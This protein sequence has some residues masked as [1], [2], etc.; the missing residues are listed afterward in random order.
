M[1]RARRFGGLAVFLAAGAAVV[2]W[3]RRPPAR[4]R[5]WTVSRCEL[6]SAGR[7]GGAPAVFFVTRQG[8]NYRACQR[9]SDQPGVTVGERIL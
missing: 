2:N 1:N 3:A 9:C 5:G 8:V 7:P 6:C 4:Y